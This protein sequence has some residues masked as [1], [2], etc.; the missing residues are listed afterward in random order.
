M[1]IARVAGGSRA[2][3]PKPGVLASTLSVGSTVKLVE[4]DVATNYLIVHQGLPSSLYDES[5]NGTWLLRSAISHDGTWHSTSRNIYG[6]SAMHSYLNAGFLARFDSKTQEII[7]QV[8]I[9]VCS[10]GGSSTIASGANGL[11][12]KA[13]LLSGYEVG[14]T[15]DNDSKF[16][17]DGAKLSYFEYGVGTSAKNKRA[18][19]DSWWTRS[20]ITTLSYYVWVV[21]QTGTFDQV[22]ETVAYG[23]RPALILPSNA[24][25]DSDTLVLKGVA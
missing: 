1:G 5:C 16:P 13:F 25:F 14:F 4:N 22:A 7:K 18:S 15:T 3:E 6:A 21:Y 10:G 2:A 20:P 9:P 19:T 11:S 12:T 24:V 23:I 8:K 17:I